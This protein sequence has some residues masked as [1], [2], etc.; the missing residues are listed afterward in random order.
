MTNICNNPFSSVVI[1]NG[2]LLIQCCELL[3]QRG[4]NIRAVVSAKPDIIQWA[5][6][7]DL[8]VINPDEKIAEK[9]Q[10]HS[11]DWLFS[12]ANLSIIPNEAL[13]QARI[14]AVNFHDGPLPEYAGL[15]APV[16][17][18]INQEKTHGISWHLIESGIDEGDVIEHHMFDIS[19]DE[20]ALTL[21]AKC[22]EAAL[23]SFPALLE[24]LESQNLHRVPQDLDMRQYY[25]L[26][27]RPDAASLLDFSRTANEVLALGRALDHGPYQNPVAC[28]KI[29]FQGQVYL[30]GKITEAHN[31]FQ[32]DATAGTVL[33]VTA[34][35]VIVATKTT[36]VQLQNISDTDGKSV[37]V[38]E[39]FTETDNIKPIESQFATDVTEMMRT[40][41]KSE[42]FWRERLTDI[43]PAELPHM[44]SQKNDTGFAQHP[45]DLPASLANDEILAV[46]AAWVAR[47]CDI[48][49][50][51]LAFRD[52]NARQG[53]NPQFCNDWVPVRF[54][55]PDHSSFQQT[56]KRFIDTLNTARTHRSFARDLWARSPSINRELMPTI[57]ITLG[58]DLL[59]ITGVA[60]TIGI[61]TDTACLQY[62]TG[63]FSKET[64]TRFATQIERLCKKQA[65][66]DLSAA[67]ISQLP[68]LSSKEYDEAVYRWNDTQEEYDG[69][70][71]I[72]HMFEAQVARTPNAQAVVFED[73]TIT[74]A[75]LNA[76]ANRVAS[77]LRDMG[78][79]PDT[80]VGLF[81]HRSLG[82]VIGALAIQKAGGAYVPLDPAYPENRIT[83][84]IKD[85]D[86]PVI[87]TE[88]DLVDELPECTADVLVLDT[89]KRIKSA[90]D[91]NIESGVTS[92]NLAYIIYT[93]GST[94]LPKGVMVQHNNVANLFKGMDE[95][96]NADPSDVWLA[97]TSL[98]FDISV[99][100]LF[101]TLARG[102]KVVVYAENN[103]I[104][105][106]DK[107]VAI[108]KQKMDFSLYNWGDDTGEGSN[109]YELLLEG[110][111]F[112]DKNGFCAVWTPERHFHSFGGLYP[113]PS[114]TGAAVAAV[115][116]NLSVRAGSIVA[117]LHHPIRIAEEWA[118]IDN[119]TNGRVGLAFASGWQP[120]DFVLRPENT[121]PEN[122][123]AMFDAIKTVRKL[124]AGEAV[125]F[126]TKN[127]APLDIVTQ[128][129]PQSTEL[130]VWVTTAG[131]PQTWIDAGKVGA[132]I[133]TH[134]L[135]QTAQEVQEKITV[136]HNAL[137]N[138]GHD[139]KDFTVTLMLHTLVGSDR[140]EVREM[141]HEPMKNYLR[142]AAG[143]IKQYAWDFPAFKKPKGVENA[144]DLDL[145]C[146]SHADM[147]AIL[148][149]AFDRYFEEA[150][151]FGTVEDCLKRVE[152]L[153]QIGVG[154]IACLVDYGL[155][156]DKVLAGLKPLAEVVKQANTPTEIS[157]NDYSMG[158]Q[159]IRHKVTH[160]QCTPSMMRMICEDEQ[161]RKSLRYIKHL[162]IG[163]E[164]M[165]GSLIDDL[166]LI[167]DAQITNMYGPT[168][169]TIWSSSE[170]AKSTDGLVNIGYPI[171]NT[172]LYILDAAQQ[173]VSNGAPGELYI[174]GD[175]VTR[176]YW[177]RPNLTEER[178]LPNPFIKQTRMY[179]TG[180][181]VCRREDGK[182]DFMGRVD[183]QI[184]LRGYRIELGEIE[185][186]LEMLDDI[187]QAV[188]VTKEFGHD[189]IRLVA[190]LL[191]KKHVSNTRLREVLS[192][193]LP[194]YMIP[195]HFVTLDKMP[196]TPNRKVDRKALPTPLSP[197]II[198]VVAEFDAPKSATEQKIAAIWARILGVEKISAG[199]NFFDLGGHSL[200]V[201]QAHKEINAEL[202]ENVL[203]ITDIFRFPTLTTLVNQIDTKANPA[204]NNTTVSSDEFKRRAEIRQSSISRRKAMRTRRS[205]IAI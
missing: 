126:P 25:G 119:L 202:G 52:A 9:L 154:E 68:I 122:K 178:F 188:V 54:D 101:Y 152:E 70:I 156:V 85:S 145:E 143:L 60:L 57:G 79:G 91:C 161:S 148:N 39:V 185:G 58:D 23:N 196:L 123:P 168:E 114:V 121:P 198:K 177:Q 112:A 86:A 63:Q 167:T 7:R 80:L 2:A 204:T 89:D 90:P 131:N 16:W 50:Y 26:H 146:V 174:G 62:N 159:I 153:K 73:K 24:K 111:K 72:H 74:Y 105:Y 124:W 109:K 67:S 76:Q 182:L 115:T 130:P 41:V 53:L 162:M 37:V 10:S 195:S 21:N 66:G 132:N 187:Q 8:P 110:A 120:N 138:A 87:I 95:R 186:C 158:A 14:G 106:Q 157:D 49:T 172:Q 176:G 139:P 71:C 175:G 151:L 77:T 135:G 42:P 103:R 98:S 31:E 3:W 15:N 127:G 43:I 55:A 137:R 59:P 48:S 205:E 88:S 47:I 179:R 22:F 184:K 142:S 140:Q 150:G 193:N 64:I 144:F 28:P 96:I 65:E 180:D 169:A 4:H 116:E 117:P 104:I 12:I 171:S 160:L 18:L 99:L 107:N 78:V 133:L 44:E 61:S 5:K 20:T 81:T 199:D 164:A 17:A 203:S 200:L 94:G 56:S 192:S 141:A 51:D 92:E 93:S 40:L 129:R 36:S 34:D 35:T 201:I 183:S 136:Y 165:P 190:Y 170:K 38:N 108:D 33:S 11:F 82:L 19:L 27:D 147:D 45:L 163:G 13:A 118:I 97:V 83:H 181:L 69:S 30:I 1:G 194:N 189:D 134:L 32:T 84:F 75:E 29:I 100:E 191:S 197:N 173:P 46:A 125:K 128:P 155:P 102:C 149:F 166:A 6:L 113:N